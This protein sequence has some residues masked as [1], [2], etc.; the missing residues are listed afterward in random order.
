MPP[1]ANAQRLEIPSSS[2]TRSGRVHYQRRPAR[3]SCAASSARQMDLRISKTVRRFQPSTPSIS[4]LTIQALV[5]C[6]EPA[7]DSFK[8]VFQK[9]SHAS[10]RGRLPYD[11]KLW[12][13]WYLKL[14]RNPTGAIAP[15]ALPRTSSRK[16]IRGTNC[17]TTYLKRPPRSFLID[18]GLRGFA[19]RFSVA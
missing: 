5:N 8:D 4:K 18:R 16:A 9:F 19:F 17:A 2:L 12:L 10:Q 6:T 3:P 15:N 13:N 14:S 11:M 7:T 1:G